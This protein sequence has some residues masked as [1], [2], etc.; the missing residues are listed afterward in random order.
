MEKGGIRQET[1]TWR[2]SLVTGRRDGSET[3]GKTEY[4][5]GKKKEIKGATNHGTNM[6]C[7]HVYFSQFAPFPLL[8]A[9]LFKM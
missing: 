4:A 9:Y 8:S 2:K 1:Q 3:E 6:T 5:K 7:P